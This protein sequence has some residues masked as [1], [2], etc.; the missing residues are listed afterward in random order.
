M[1]E[2]QIV[3]I[4]QLQAKRSHYISNPRQ[5][6]FPHSKF[7]PDVRDVVYAKLEPFKKALI[8]Y[9]IPHE[10]LSSGLA[11]L[12]SLQIVSEA[13]TPIVRTLRHGVPDHEL[14]PRELART[15]L[16]DGAS[17]RIRPFSESCIEPLPEHPFNHLFRQ[18]L[19]LCTLRKSSRGNG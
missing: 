5:I 6:V 1:D 8:A 12:D 11:F 16:S 7:L 13:R 17:Q 10:L 9:P 2:P 18:R 15:R 14:Q 4:G 19:A 3:F